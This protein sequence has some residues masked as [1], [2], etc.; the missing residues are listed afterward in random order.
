[1]MQILCTVDKITNYSELLPSLIFNLVL[2]QAHIEFSA[3]VVLLWLVTIKKTFC[4][5]GLIKFCFLD[6]VTNFDLN[7]NEDLVCTYYIVP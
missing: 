5:I 3:S 1:M 2:I 4:F 7:Q 6:G